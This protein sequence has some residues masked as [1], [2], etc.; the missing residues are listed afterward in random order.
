MS[1]RDR[2][3]IDFKRTLKREEENVQIKRERHL[4]LQPEADRLRNGKQLRQERLREAGRNVQLKRERPRRREP[5]QPRNAEH[6]ALVISLGKHEFRTL[7]LARMYK[8]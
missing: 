3:S 1:Q 8:K 7:Q 2:P 6:Y 4:R 5:D